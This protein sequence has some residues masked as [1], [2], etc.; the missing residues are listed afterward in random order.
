[1]AAGM[2]KDEINNLLDTEPGLNKYYKEKFTTEKEQKDRDFQ[3]YRLGFSF[4]LRNRRA[5]EKLVK[6][7]KGEVWRAVVFTSVAGIGTGLLIQEGIAVGERW[8]GHNVGP[9]ILENLVGAKTAEAAPLDVDSRTM[10]DLFNQPRNLTLPDGIQL[11][12]DPNLHDGVKNIGLWDSAGNRVPTPPMELNNQGH[13]LMQG[14]MAK[15]PDAAKKLFEGW[16]IQPHPGVDVNLHEKLLSQYLQHCGPAV[17][18]KKYASRIR[19]RRWLLPPPY[20]WSCRR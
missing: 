4:K 15:L 1:M 9:T 2:S 8:S 10:V 6:F 14:D 7:G 13:I 16:N 17:S 11:R 19:D 3:A 12:I 20:H 18:H 5:G